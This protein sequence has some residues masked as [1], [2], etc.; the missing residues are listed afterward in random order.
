M[1]KRLFI[2]FLMPVFIS[3]CATT[4]FIAN[5]TSPR[6]LKISGKDE[7]LEVI[8]NYLI[9]PDGPGAWVKDALWDE[10]ALTIRNLSD[11]TLTVEKFRLID[12]RGVYI[13]SGVN[14]DQLESATKM[15]A[16]VYKD[17]GIGV[18]VGAGIT[19]LG[20]VAPLAFTPVGM[21]A[22][23]LYLGYE[24][25]KNFT[26]IADREKTSKEFTRRNLPS[27]TLSGNATVSGSAFFPIVP[28]PKALVVDYR[29]GTETKI[30]EISMEELAGFHVAPAKEKKK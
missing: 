2:L 16:E 4:R 28:N 12:P 17:A 27:V 23:P 15:L 8:L 13:E 6:E 10:Y 30:L 29:R 3:G 20:F 9:I 1:I 26:A 11:K 25:N 14:P 5:P 18:V 22:G 7:N 19:A 21:V 24:L